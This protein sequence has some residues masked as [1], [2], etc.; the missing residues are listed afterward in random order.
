MKIFSNLEIKPLANLETSLH[1]RFP[2]IFSY[3]GQAR[4]SWRKQIP[5]DYVHTKSFSSISQQSKW[6]RYEVFSFCS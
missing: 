3:F 5:L 6:K 4:E 2:S 1:E